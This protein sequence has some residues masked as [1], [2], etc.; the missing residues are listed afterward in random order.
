MLTLADKFLIAILAT[1]TLF[2][3]SIGNSGKQ[4]TEVRIEVEGKAAGIYSLKKDGVHKISGALG[5]S[6][7]SIKDEKASFVSSPCKNKVCIHQ[8]EIG[9]SGQMAACLPNK[10]VARLVGEN[11][12]YDAIT[13]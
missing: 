8:G 7:I 1:L 9:K 13:R 6:V 11:G 3:Y 2:S 5:D 4:G 10:V 12:D